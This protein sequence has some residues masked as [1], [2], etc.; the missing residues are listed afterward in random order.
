MLELGTHA[1]RLRRSSKNEW[2]GGTEGFYWGCNNTKDRAVRLE[3]IA[4][5]NDRP[6]NVVWEPTDRD[7]TW[8]RLYNEN[9]GKITGDFGRLAFTT[10]PLAAIAFSRCEIHNLRNGQAAGIVCDLRSA[11]GKAM[12]TNGG[13]EERSIREFG[14]SSVIRGQYFIPERH[15]QCQVGSCR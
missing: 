8:I 11:N 14:R 5:L 4:S 1:S 6:E 12:G 3:T 9:K 2:Y 7:R 15:R 10:P 13:G